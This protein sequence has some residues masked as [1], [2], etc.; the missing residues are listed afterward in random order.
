[1]LSPV[2]PAEL[3]DLPRRRV[4][5]PN[6]EQFIVCSNIVRIDINEPGKRGTHGWQLRRGLRTKFYSDVSRVL[7]TNSALDSL[8]AAVDALARRYEGPLL[9]SRHI[10]IPTKAIKSGFPGIRIISRKRKGRHCLEFWVEVCCPEG[11]RSPKRFYVGT[12]TTYS[13]DALQSKI[14]EAFVYRKTMQAAIQEQRNLA[15]HTEL[16]N[17]LSD[18]ASE[19]L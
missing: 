6:G 8:Q 15:Y 14:K 5:L 10:E 19:S 3:H 11:K 13:D 16:K 9:L 7:N 2:F 12:E 18:R 4:T 1:M 17:K